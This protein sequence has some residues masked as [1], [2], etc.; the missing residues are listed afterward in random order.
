VFTPEIGVYKIPVGEKVSLTQFIFAQKVLYGI[1]EGKKKKDI[2]AHFH[3]SYRVP[4]HS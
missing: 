4:S 2:D 3:A 1:E